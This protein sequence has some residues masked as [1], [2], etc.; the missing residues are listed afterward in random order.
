M[1]SKQW[2]FT[3][4][5]A[6]QCNLR[7]HKY[8]IQSGSNLIQSNAI[9]NLQWEFC[10]WGV[11]LRWTGIVFVVYC[12][13]IYYSFIRLIHAIKDWVSV[14]YIL[15]TTYYIILINRFRRTSSAIYPAHSRGISPIPGAF[16]SKRG[17]SSVL[18]CINPEEVQLSASVTWLLKRRSLPLSFYCN[19]LLHP[20]LIVHVMVE[21]WWSMLA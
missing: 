3:P 6:I 19:I 17:L 2:K 1:D 9:C 4:P 11:A 16:R 8:Q 5:Y 13:R 14:H 18:R 20:I 21:L 15:C 7:Q 10:L 12:G